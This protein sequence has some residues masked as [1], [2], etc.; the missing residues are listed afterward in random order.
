V[1]IKKIAMRV[2]NAK[3]IQAS[4]QDDLFYSGSPIG[5][6]F[7]RMLKLVVSCGG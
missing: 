5:K 1:E 3:E 7:Y 6:S 2:I 4:Y